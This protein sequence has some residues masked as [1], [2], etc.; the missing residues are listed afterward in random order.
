MPTTARN[1]NA[2]PA[3]KAAAADCISSSGVVK[4]Q[5]PTDAQ[6]QALQTCL[7]AAGIT[8]GDHHGSDHGS[9]NKRPGNKRH[10]P[11]TP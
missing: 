10:V 9:G 11:V 7:A 8:K 3:K 6:R 5:K 4:G 2:D 1:A